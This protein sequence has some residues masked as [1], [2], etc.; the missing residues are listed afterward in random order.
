MRKTQEI[1]CSYVRNSW[2]IL[3][4]QVQGE[5]ETDKTN[6]GG[7]E[8]SIICCHK[9]PELWRKGNKIMIFFF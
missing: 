4:N 5:D 7:L 9:T 6:V 2:I 8:E 3:C 1:I